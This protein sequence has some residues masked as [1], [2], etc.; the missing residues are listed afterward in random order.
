MSQNMN[1]EENL[2]QPNEE[3]EESQ[4]DKAAQEVCLY[5]IL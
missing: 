5:D 1:K 2:E 3:L 4:P